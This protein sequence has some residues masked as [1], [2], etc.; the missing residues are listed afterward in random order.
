MPGGGSGG[1][2]GSAVAVTAAGAVLVWSGV[3]G[4]SLTGTLRSLVSGKAPAT[5]EVNT[6]TNDSTSTSATTEPAST[7][8]SAI[9]ND[10][11]QY[12]GHAYKYGGAPGTD[13]AAPWDCSS[14][15]NWVLGHDLGMA[16]PGDGTP[17]YSGASHG[18]TTLSYLAWGQ[19]ETV[20]HTASVA[21]PGDL[22][23]WQTH[24]GICTGPDQMISAQDPALGT[25]VSNI[26]LPGELLFV[27]R[28]LDPGA[29]A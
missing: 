17:G 23:V 5:A 13:G 1:I 9:A 19:A 4:T 28:I 2:P 16:L 15:V 24:M 10:A 14:F 20:G 29:P 18:P 11:L 22:C 12:A 26:A 27:R 8:G 3:R 21:Q 6:L 25:G 7:T